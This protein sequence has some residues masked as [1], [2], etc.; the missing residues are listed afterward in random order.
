MS[1]EGTCP[2]CGRLI[3]ESTP[4]SGDDDRVQPRAPWHFKLLMVALVIYLAYRFVQGVQWAMAH[5]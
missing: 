4:E 2:T 1:E 3:A 5:H